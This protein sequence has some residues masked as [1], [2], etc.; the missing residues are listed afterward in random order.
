MSSLRPSRRDYITL[1]GIEPKDG[2]LTC[3]VQISFE[4]M[5]AVGR[6]S[7]GHAKECGVIVPMILEKPS[8]I[9]EGCGETRTRTAGASVGGAIA[10]C[11][12][13]AIARTARRPRR[14]SARFTSFSSTTSGSPIIGGGRRPTLIILTSPSATRRDSNSGYS[15]HSVRLQ[16]PK[17]GAVSR[18]SG[19]IMDAMPNSDFAKRMMLLAGLPN[20][21]SRL[22]STTPTETASSSSPNPTVLC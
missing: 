3:E 2:T 9:F 1:L 11:L 16:D 14:T 5:Q 12:N 6:R 22:R 8:A 18:F 15:E 10:A 7:M 13:T 17:P 4:R 21:S 20:S 19:V